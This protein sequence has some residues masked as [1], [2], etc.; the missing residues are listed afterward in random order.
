MK[1]ENKSVTVSKDGPFAPSF[2]LA[3]GLPLRLEAGLRYF[4]SRMF[5]LSLREQLNPR[6]FKDFDCSVNLNFGHL[7]NGYSYLKYGLSL[8]RDISD[9]EPYLHYTF[10]SYLGANNNDFSDSFF[11]GAVSGFIDNCRVLGFGIGIPLKKIKIFPEADYQHS[12]DNFSSGL[13]HFG[14]GIRVYTN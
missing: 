12:S 13:W 14:I 11:A 1:S 2:G 5:E 7:V 8:S 10:Y 6:D 9:F 3:Y 4:P